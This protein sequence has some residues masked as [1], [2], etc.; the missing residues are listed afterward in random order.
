MSDYKKDILNFARKAEEK[1]KDGADKGVKL[2][3]EK[4]PKAVDFAKKS[5]D[6]ASKFAK[7]KAPVVKD[8]AKDVGNE[9]YD[10]GVE[11]KD[12]ATNK[13]NEYKNRNHIKV[14]TTKDV[15][16]TEDENKE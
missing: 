15:I 9:L 14:S 12:Y 13:Y 11:A 5:A 3:K 7:E 1:V 8:F 6:K 10:A 4:A 2:A 16:N